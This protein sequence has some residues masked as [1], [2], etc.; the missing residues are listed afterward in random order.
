MTTPISD[1]FDAINQGSVVVVGTSDTHAISPTDE[2]RLRTLIRKTD[3]LARSDA[4]GD[5]PPLCDRSACWA[6]QTLHFLCRTL[7]D[8][9]DVATELP[10]DLAANRPSGTSASEHWSV[11]L[12][13]RVLADIDRRC[14]GA[15][16]LDPLRT[17]IREL[18]AHWPLSAIGIQ[19]D[20]SPKSMSVV[21]SHPTLR[22]ILVDRIVA[23]GDADR[24][25]LPC[26]ADEIAA[27]TPTKIPHL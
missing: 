10:A 9:I 11:D 3:R 8:R 19:T 27:A 4:P 16:Q 26:V 24:A 14:A 12:V 21:L 17:T 2:D 18:A 5:A 20:L 15:N 6:A 25:T 13:L 1:V 7:L 22:R 23:R